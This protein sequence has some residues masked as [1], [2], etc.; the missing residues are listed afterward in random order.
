M[1]INKWLKKNSFFLGNTKKSKKEVEILLSFVIK[2]PISWII[3]F[4]ENKL[5]SNYLNKLKYLIKRRYLGEPIDYIIGKSYFWSLPLYISK[6]SMIPRIDSEILVQQT[7]KFIPIDKKFDVLDLGCG[8]GSLTLSLA[9]ERPNCFFLGV[10]NIDN[11]IYLS[12]KNAKK[13]KI[14]N[15]RFIKSNWFSKLEN[16]NFNII[17]SNPPYISIYDPHLI[18]GDLRFEPLTSLVSKNNGLFDIQYISKNANNFLRKKGWLLFEH[19]W[20]QAKYVRNILKKNDFVKVFTKKDYG[21][22]DRITYGKK[23]NKN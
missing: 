3:A 14:N 13:L 21:N 19:G 18:L 6:K 5:N 7:L 20:Y 23:N 1:K 8:I 10:D 4:G 11:L 17:L 15:V 22:N 2:K 9:R 12:K 16:K